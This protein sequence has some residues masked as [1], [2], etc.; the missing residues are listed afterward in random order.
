MIRTASVAGFI[1]MAVCAA[2]LLFTGI[3][4]QPHYLDMNQVEAITRMQHPEYNNKPVPQSVINELI[5]LVNSYHKRIT[6][7][8]DNA[9]QLQ[10]L[11][12]NIAQRYLDIAFYEQ[13]IEFYINQIEAGK[14]PPAGADS[15]AY[16]DYAAL[17]LMQKKLYSQAYENLQES[18]RLSPDNAFL[19][20]YSGYSAALIGKAMRPENE[21]EGMVWLDKAIKYYQQALKINPDYIEA[22]YGM[23]V[24]LVY[25]T[26]QPD[27]GIPFLLHIKQ[28]NPEN[29]DA[30]FVLASAYTMTGDNDAAIAEYT[31][32]EKIATTDEKKKAARDNISLLRGAP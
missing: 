1:G 31:E 4:C 9:E 15:G 13:Q 26:G 29:T 27:K 12:K 21:A 20:Y 19:L 30:R 2:F 3:S 25:E 5:P 14:N 8:A 17:M 10:L 7:Y 24:I 32:I 18:L 23:A 11:Y 16:Y 28:K 6:A 22:L